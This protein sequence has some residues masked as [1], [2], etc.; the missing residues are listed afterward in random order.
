MNIEVPCGL[1]ICDIGCRCVVQDSFQCKEC[2]DCFLRW[3]YP[4]TVSVVAMHSFMME[5]D[6]HTILDALTLAAT[7][8]VIYMMMFQLKHTYQVELDT[9]LTAYVVS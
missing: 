1:E 9:I 6:I 3:S 2:C 5:Y 4:V 8:Y 7:V